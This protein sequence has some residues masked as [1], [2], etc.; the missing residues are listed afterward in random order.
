M[1]QLYCVTCYSE[2]E[3]ERSCVTWNR[4]DEVW[5]TD[6]MKKE[7]NMTEREEG[8]E[9]EKEKSSGGK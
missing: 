8:D 6:V 7:I 3:R 1:R 9:N 5:R 2:K 4:L